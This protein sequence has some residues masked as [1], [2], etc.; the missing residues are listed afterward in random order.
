M[1][2]KS[3]IVSWGLEWRLAICKASLDQSAIINKMK[4]AVF[5]FAFIFPSQSIAI[6]PAHSSPSRGDRNWAGEWARKY[7]L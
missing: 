3:V 6:R 5:Y 4:M 2:T 1:D 7:D